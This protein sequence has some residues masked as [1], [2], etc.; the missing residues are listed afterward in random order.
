MAFDAGV[1]LIRSTQKRA[2]V[3]KLLMCLGVVALLVAQ[4]AEIAAA[5]TMAG[6]LQYGA[7]GLLALMIVGYFVWVQPAE[8]AAK[9]RQDQTHAQAIQALVTDHRQVIRDLANDHKQAMDKIAN[10]HKEAVTALASQHE[11]STSRICDEIKTCRMR[12]LA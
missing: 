4:G 2:E 3:V 6:W 9:E 8:R 10:E 5:Q 12:G 1:S 11:A 7:F